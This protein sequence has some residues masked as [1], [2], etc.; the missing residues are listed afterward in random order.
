MK[1]IK[2]QRA[3]SMFKPGQK[4][5]ESGVYNAV[6]HPEHRH[7]HSLLLR[8]GDAFPR[9]SRCESTVFLKV[10]TAPH[11]AEDPDFGARKVPKRTS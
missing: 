5:L 2:P 9:C 4:V 6:H 1:L 3:D 7:S 8:V 11:F 10:F